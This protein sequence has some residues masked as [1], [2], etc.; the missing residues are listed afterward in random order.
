ME[1]ARHTV[2]AEHIL[3]PTN[4][5]TRSRPRDAE[6]ALSRLAGLAARA[7]QRVL[8]RDAPALWDVETFRAAALSVDTREESRYWWETLTAFARAL[9]LLDKE[10][11][12]ADGFRGTGLN[13][14]AGLKA[15]F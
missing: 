2:S 14:L 15:R 12:V 11:E 13:V 5:R 10:Y 3:P 8:L 1:P 7:R 4:I 9:N 6:E